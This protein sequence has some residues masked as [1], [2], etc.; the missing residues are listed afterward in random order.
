MRDP[1]EL[2]D[3]LLS[4]VAAPPAAGVG[5]SISRL[6]PAKDDASRFTSPATRALWGATER[7]RE[8]E[9]AVPRRPLRPDHPLPLGLAAKHDGVDA[10]DAAVT[11]VQGHLEVSG[12]VTVEELANMPPG[13]RRASVGIALEALRGRGFAV[14]GRFEPE[15]GRA[16][17]CSPAAGAHPLLH[18]RAPARRG[19]PDHPRRVAG[20]PRV[21]G[22]TRLPGR[23]VHGRAGLAEVI[24]QLQGFEWPA[25]EWE[26]IFAERVESYRP[27][28]LDDLCLSGEVTWGRLSLLEPAVKG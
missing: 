24:E 28:W 12:P 2:H 17:V 11:V 21:A 23:S 4:L 27:E 13:C 22:G 20:V 3:V 14:A 19:P 5:T 9:A 26:R 7:R 1:D 25:G 16:V 15:R 18:A 6:S 10:D 8:L